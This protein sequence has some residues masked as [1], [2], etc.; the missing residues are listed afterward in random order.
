MHYP[1][2]DPWGLYHRHCGL[3]DRPETERE[4]ILQ[5]IENVARYRKKKRLLRSGLSRFRRMQKGLKRM[6]ATL[7]GLKRNE[8]P[9]ETD[10][11]GTAQGRLPSACPVNCQAKTLKTTPQPPQLPT[12]STRQQPQPC[13]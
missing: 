12:M 8:R 5:R 4:I 9:A 1:H 11:N 10:A 13:G 6:L 2:I 7:P 3:R